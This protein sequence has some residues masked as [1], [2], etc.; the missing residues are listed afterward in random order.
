[1]IYIYLC[2]FRYS[3]LQKKDG[4]LTPKGHVLGFDQFAL[5]EEKEQ[6]L[7]LMPAGELEVKEAPDAFDIV[8]DRIHYR[9]GKTQ[10]AFLSMQKDGEDLIEAPVEWCVFRAPIDNDVPLLKEWEAAGY[11]R[12]WTK[13]YGCSAKTEDGKAIISCRFS[14][15]SVY[16]QPF[17]QIEA[18]WEINAEGSVKLTLHAERNTE[19]P[20][21]PRFGLTFILP[22]DKT[23]VTYLGYGPY[24][25]YVDKHRASWIERF[26]TCVEEL[27]EDY[28]KPQE[29]G[30]HYHC[31]EV[32]VGKF[33]CRYGICDRERSGNNK[34]E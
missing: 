24:E 28:V 29:N 11:D 1:M 22:R 32:Q 33:C 3:Y 5:F 13:V 6:E 14:I 23:K 25:S 12:P 15:A 4:L 19:F 30:S 31:Y 18:Q 34:T 16:R 10:A 7:L 27:H 2:D 21:L 9:F 26:E 20:A 8:S 17:L